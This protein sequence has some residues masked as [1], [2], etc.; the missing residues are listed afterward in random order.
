MSSTDM[1]CLLPL[2]TVIGYVAYESCPAVTPTPT[3]T[4]ICVA[5]F[6]LLLVLGFPLHLIH[7]DYIIHLLVLRRRRSC[8]VGTNGT[9][10]TPLL[11]TLRNC[12]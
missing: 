1:N 3:V 2:C 9:T 10:N 7:I 11:Y 5:R 4:I 6:L 8:L 12:T